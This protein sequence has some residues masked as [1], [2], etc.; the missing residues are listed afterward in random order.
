MT[1]ADSPIILIGAARSGTKFLRDVLRVADG[2]GAVPY[3]VNYV[4][5]YGF[6]QHPHDLLPVDELSQK[7]T[8][9]IQKTLRSLA[10]LNMDDVLIE[11]TV[12][13]TLRVPFVDA[14]YPNARYVHLIRDG[15]DVT[16]SAMRQWLA[17]PNWSALFTKLRGMPFSNLG[18]VFWFAK[19]FIS[20]MLKGQ[21]G[22]NVWGP[23]FDG[24]DDLVGQKSLAYICAMQWR[25][26]V[27]QATQ[28]LANIPAE[29]VFEIRY[30]DLVKDD[31]AITNLLTQLDIKD[32]AKVV[33]H[34]RDKVHIENTARWKNLPQN[35]QADMMSVIGDTLK[36]KDYDYV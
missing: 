28:D 18:Y 32:S 9:F 19:N 20:G 14:V 31:T 11:K 4:W 24:I 3:D 25:K 5:R 23:R 30:E 21:K 12:S 6:E 26:S 8:V 29:R 36:L 1:N 34:W 16:E 22:G 7:Q 27:E 15:R 10:S 35:D 13:N 33:N 2:H 17:P